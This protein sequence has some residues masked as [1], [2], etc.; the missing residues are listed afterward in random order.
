[1]GHV[2]CK[3]EVFGLGSHLLPVHEEGLVM[4]TPEKGGSAQPHRD[5]QSMC[6]VG[7]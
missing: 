1:M 7:G 3:G 5:F 2:Q 6:S 4:L